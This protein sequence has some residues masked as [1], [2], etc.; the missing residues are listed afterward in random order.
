LEAPS[1]V[2]AHGWITVDGQKMGKSLGNA[3][4]PFALIETFGADSMRY[5]LLREAPFGSEFSL[6]DEKIAQRHNSD[7]GNDLG[8]LLHR[9]L[10]M[11]SK[12]RDG[13]VPRGRTEESPFAQRFGG[14]A[15]RVR[16]SIV[17]L[18]FREALEAVWELVTALNRAIDERKPWTLHKEG[19][20]AELDELL[21]D[22]AEGLRVLAM[23]LYPFMPERMAEMWRRLG[24]SG[25][26]DG[27]WSGAAWGGLTP[28][29]QTHSGDPLFPRVELVPAVT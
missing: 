3:A 24:V 29:T 11:L 21:Y 26:I 18:R 4:D 14:L 16:A 15:D 9:T 5:F 17:D 28:G 7:L 2:Y 8:N 13:A 25:A 1:L 10:S 27:D 12:Y 6:S 23:L 19:K 20:T 22:L